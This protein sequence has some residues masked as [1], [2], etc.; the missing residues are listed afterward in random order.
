MDSTN[1]LEVLIYQR[2][3]HDPK[4]FE[5]RELRLPSVQVDS[6]AGQ[7]EAA[8]GVHSLTA[9]SNFFSTPTNSST[10]QYGLQFVKWSSE[11]PRQL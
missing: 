9:W 7:V 1:R 10:S 3:V 5:T 2:S 4:L 11:T 8:E 6:V